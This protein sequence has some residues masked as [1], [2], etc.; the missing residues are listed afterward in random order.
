MHA[1][2]ID[3]EPDGFKRCLFASIPFFAEIRQRYKAVRIIS[4]ESHCE[5]RHI[6][7]DI[8]TDHIHVE[9]NATD[10]EGTYK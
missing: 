4:D 3:Y 9:H 1:V 8:H 7:T 6:D 2:Y 10:M 5:M